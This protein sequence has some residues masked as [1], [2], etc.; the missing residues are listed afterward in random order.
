MKLADS[1]ESCQSMASTRA[2]K[3]KF[4]DL[5]LFLSFNSYFFFAMVSVSLGGFAS[6][7]RREEWKVSLCLVEMMNAFSVGAATLEA[8]IAG[9]EAWN[10]GTFRN[11]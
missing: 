9:W 1:V 10:L 4:G 5:S 8:I 7:R 11:F 6:F 3:S 2:L